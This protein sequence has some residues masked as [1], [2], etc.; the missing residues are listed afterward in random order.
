VH[1]VPE[2]TFALILA[3]RRSLFGYAR[4]VAAASGS[5]RSSSACPGHPI[6]D[7]HG[8]TI[9]I[10]GEGALGQGVAHLARGFGMRVLFADHPPPKAEASSSPGLT[11]CCAKAG[12]R[13]AAMRPLTGGDPQPDRRARARA[14]EEDGAGDQHR[15]AADW[16]T[17][18]RC[19][20][21]WSP[22]GSPAPASTC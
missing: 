15:A 22:D 5:A 13:H 6:N 18:A 21:R 7:I 12:H 4:D 20:T 19:A 2:H 9:G 8:S 3:L 11:R 16:S 1:T 17:R 14:D 10:F